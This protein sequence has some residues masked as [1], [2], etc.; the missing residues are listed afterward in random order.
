MYGVFDETTFDALGDA[1]MLE[2]GHFADYW[3]AHEKWSKNRN[4][5]YLTVFKSYR[6]TLLDELQ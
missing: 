5:K 1:Y 2:L 6:K 4:E 3:A